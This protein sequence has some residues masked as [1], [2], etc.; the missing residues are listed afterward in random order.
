MFYLR[1]SNFRSSSASWGAKPSHDFLSSGLIIEAGDP[2]TWYGALA[3]ILKYL[4]NIQS[5]NWFKLWIHFHHS[6]IKNQ[7]NTEISPF[8]SLF[9]ES[10]QWGSSCNRHFCKQLNNR[11]YVVNN[12]NFHQKKIWW[13]NGSCIWPEEFGCGFN[14]GIGEVAVWVLAIC[15]RSFAF[16]AGKLSKT[17][18]FPP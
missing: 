2:F 13:I 4:E 10:M 12:W 18:T 8:F 7:W 1:Y 3:I 11:A 6:L 9:Q 5:I 14:A 17:S 16:S 15:M